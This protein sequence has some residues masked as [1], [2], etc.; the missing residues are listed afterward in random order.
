LERCYKRQS[1]NKFSG[2]GGFGSKG[3]WRRALLFNS[4]SAKGGKGK[5]KGKS[6]GG[7]KGFGRGKGKVGKWAKEKWAKERMENQPSTKEAHLSA[8]FAWK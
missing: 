8:T 4:H 3:K 5:S 2:K 7:G 6:K 1:P